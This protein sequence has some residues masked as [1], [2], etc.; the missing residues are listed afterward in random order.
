LLPFCARA[1]ASDATSN[2]AAAIGT[3]RCFF[4]VF[5]R[6]IFRAQFFE[7][8]TVVAN[9]IHQLSEARD[10]YSPERVGNY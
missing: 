7:R 2:K 4:I 8:G 3:L 9:Y 5:L 10:T 1:I 6:E